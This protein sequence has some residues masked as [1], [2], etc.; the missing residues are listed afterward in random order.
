MLQDKSTEN[1]DILL[2]KQYHYKNLVLLSNIQFTFKHPQL[3]Q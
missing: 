2:H 3:S 1:K